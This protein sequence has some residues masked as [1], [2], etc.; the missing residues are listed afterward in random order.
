MPRCRA[1]GAGAAELSPG[2]AVPRNLKPGWACW[3]RG[4]RKGPRPLALPPP[5]LPLAKMAPPSDVASHCPFQ[6]W[7]RARAGAGGGGP[8]P[9]GGAGSRRQARGAAGWWRGGCARYV[10]RCGQLPPPSAGSARGR[11]VPP[12]WTTRY[13]RGGGRGAGPRAECCRG[14]GGGWI[15]R[16]GHRE[17]AARRTA[18]WGPG[19]PTEPGAGGRPAGLPS[20]GGP[21]SSRRRAS[22]GVGGSRGRDSD[23][24]PVPCGAAGPPA[25][26]ARLPLSRSP[27]PRRP[28]LIISP[29]FPPGTAGAP[30]TSVPRGGTGVT[31]ARGGTR[32]DRQGRVPGP[33][34]CLASRG[35]R[36]SPG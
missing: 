18:R 15:V 12:P 4:R 24:A 29:F 30:Q 33:R 7:R 3:L 27:G 1:A 14:G 6:R 9:G 22:S 23:V 25:P 2:S 16:R 34:G 36:R 5:S 28:P 31:P 35:R 32:S 8:A 10:G 20:T 13:G 21:F 26:P 19:H 11:R 17:A